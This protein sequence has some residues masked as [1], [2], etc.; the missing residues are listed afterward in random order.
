[1]N[2]LSPRREDG[3]ADLIGGGARWGSAGVQ[4]RRTVGE[5]DSFGGKLRGHV[6]V[7]GK[8]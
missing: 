1:M 8:R 6:T 7:G 4:V 5:P 2:D 3:G